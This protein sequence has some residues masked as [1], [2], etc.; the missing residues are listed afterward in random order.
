MRSNGQWCCGLC[1]SKSNTTHFISERCPLG[2]HTTSIHV[3][4]ALSER[5]QAIPYDANTSNHGP[6]S[7]HEWEREGRQRE[8]EGVGWG[9]GVGTGGTGRE[10]PEEE[11]KRV[12]NIR[13]PDFYL[14]TQI[15]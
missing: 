10:R 9:W 1:D 12:Q 11:R 5:F 14:E 13:V 4:H 7:I 15:V 6:Y 8:V 3:D 2:L